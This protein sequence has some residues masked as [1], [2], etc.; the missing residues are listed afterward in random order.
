MGNKPEANGPQRP[1]VLADLLQHTLEL[2]EY[3]GHLETSESTLFELKLALIRTI[4]RLERE[5]AVRAIAAN[6]REHEQAMSSR[7]APRGES[8]GITRP[9]RQLDRRA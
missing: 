5:Q 7:K 9:N 8:I 3:Y 2:V 1:C 4:D 6:G